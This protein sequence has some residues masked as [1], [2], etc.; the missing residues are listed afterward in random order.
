M[1]EALGQ[2]GVLGQKVTRH[3]YATTDTKL[4]FFQP[5]ASNVPSYSVH[6]DD[7]ILFILKLT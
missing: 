6:V 4:P 3:W 7:G 1:L 2:R 5:L